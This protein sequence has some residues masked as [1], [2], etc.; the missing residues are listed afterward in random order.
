[1]KREPLL[2]LAHRLP[3]PP[4]KGDKVRSHNFLK[5]L[6]ARYRVFLGTFVDDPADWPYVGPARAL[7]AGTQVQELARW[8]RPA[9]GASAFL[10]GEPVT[11][12]YFRSRALLQWVREVVEHERIERAFVY[13][14]SMAQ[15]VMGLP[16]LRSVVDFVDMDS[17]KWADYAALRSWP[18]SALY[19]REAR[20]LLDFEKE[21]AAHAAASVFV[22]E[23]EARRF[24]AEIG[25]RSA[26]VCA[27][28]NGVDSDYYSPAHR[29]A[30][31]FAPGERAI[32]FTGAMD[33][34]P[35]IDA[36]VWFAREVMPRLRDRGLR[37]YVVGM[38]PDSTVRALA[39]EAGTVITGRVADVR[40]YLQHAEVVVA[41]LR[42]A[43]GIQNKVLEA[44]AMGKAVVASANSAA[45][46]SARPGT[47]IEVA[48]EAADFAAKVLALVG[49]HEAR[50][51][52]ER[53]RARVLSDYVWRA[54][55]AQL[56]ALLEG[57]HVPP[58]KKALA[59]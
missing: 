42:V 52:G 14:S 20:R 23:E 56:D 35:N 48:G 50:I 19:R 58:R 4:N 41:P 55:F 15:Y 13:S 49:S 8:T 5:H 3:Y 36:V 44:M 29:F 37:F 33:Y 47:E 51:V 43:R 12:P 22:T 39:E 38:N 18:A 10:R 28:R 2:F 54:S 27:I 16:Q 34:W 24:S 46:L 9:S 7:C 25:D 31:P 11:L 40:P 32:V 1:M 26:R 53:A 30:S 45:A 17:A 57:E 21:V 59:L 6:A